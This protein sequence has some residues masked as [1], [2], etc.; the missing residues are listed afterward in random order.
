MIFSNN[1]QNYLCDFL[2]KNIPLN[3][4]IGDIIFP[5]TIYINLIVLPQQCYIELKNND[6]I[7][8]HLN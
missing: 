8:E 6:I 7:Y 1:I 2:V 4:E 3:I 5:E